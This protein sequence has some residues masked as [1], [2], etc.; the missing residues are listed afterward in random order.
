MQ[1]FSHHPPYSRLRQK[2]ITDGSFVQTTP[3]DT[4]RFITIRLSNSGHGTFPPPVLTICWCVTVRSP[5]SG[6]ADLDGYCVRQYRY[7]SRYVF[8]ICLCP[9]YYDTFHDMFHGMFVYQSALLRYLHLRSFVQSHDL[10]PVVDKFAGQTWRER[11][12]GR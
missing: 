2:N 4:S 6:Y 9:V 1:V 11:L 5:V 12:Q 10:I 8:T 7:V 3:H